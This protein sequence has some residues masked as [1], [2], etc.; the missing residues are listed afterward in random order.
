M[1]VVSKLNNLVDLARE[2]SSERRRALLREVT[3]LFFEETPARNS[4]VS[5]KFDEVLS[6]LAVQSAQEAREELAERFADSPMAP[7]GLVL[8]LARDAIEVAAPIL[9]RSVVLSDEDLVSI[10]ET[11]GQTHL[12]AISRRTEVSERLS[13]TIVRRGDD[14]TVAS[15]I[16]NEGAK[17][18]REAFE[19]VTERAETSTALQG[20]L[21]ERGDTPNDLIADLMLAVG[22]HLRDRIMERFDSVDPK[23]LEQAMEASRTRL[24]ARVAEDQAVAEAEKFVSAMAVRK[25]L[26]GG[27][28]A[29][30]LRE[31]EMV[32]FNVAFAELTGVDYITAKRA[33]EQDCIDPL[34]LICRA[35]DFD[36]ALFVTL[37]VLRNTSDASA[38][39]DAKELGTLYDSI[40]PNDAA[41]A[42]RFWRMRRDMAA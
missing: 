40:T 6:S 22:N 12:K 9:S 1:A 42:M 38:F 28:L 24:A 13:D 32:K 35:A 17:L 15:L 25:R 23:V 11:G 21:V 41:R 30:L 29:R 8:Q 14:E 33:I 2:K 19:T 20:P 18:S 3:D 10:A 26:D 31:R 4:A 16:G 5:N 27:L 39:R 36:K 37:A 7:P 34:A